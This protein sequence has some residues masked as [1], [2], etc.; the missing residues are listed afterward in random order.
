[1]GRLRTHPAF[2][3]EDVRDDLLARVEDAAGARIQG[4][5]DANPWVPLSSVE[6]PGVVDKLVGVLAWIKD[7]A[8]AGPDGPA[9]A[10]GA[11]S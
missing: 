4:N 8:D 7:I 2:E 1:M 5:R 6:K 9:T 3:D 10:E 11:S